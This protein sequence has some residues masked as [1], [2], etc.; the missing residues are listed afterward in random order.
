M[1]IRPIT[2]RK[3]ADDILIGGCS[4]TDLAKEYGT[5]LYVLDAATIQQNCQI[6]TKILTEHYPNFSIAYASKA[7]LNIG[8]ANLIAF[9]GIGADVVSGGE[10][11]TVLKSQ[12]DP[13][14]IYFHGNNKSIEELELAIANHIRLVV[15]NA[16]EVALIETIATRLNKKA[17][18]MFRIKP[19]I[20]AHT[21]EYIKTGHIDSKFG[22]EFNDILPLI[23]KIHGSE[24]G[25]FIGI[26]AHIGSQIFDMNPYYDL[27]SILVGFMDT[28]YSE[29]GIDIPELNCGGGFGIKYTE[30]DQA[31]DITDIIL[32]MA[33]ELKL[34]CDGKKRPRPKLVFEPGRS[35]IANAGV[36]IYT[37][38]TSKPISDGQQYLFIDG[39]M[40]D[41]PR[42][43]MYQSEY[44]FDVV[45]PSTTDQARYT[46]AGKFCESGDILAKNIVLPIVKPSEHIVVYGTGAYNYSMASNYNRF[47][48]PAM[49]LVNN[50]VASLL[51]KRETYEDIIRYDAL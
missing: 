44:T 9:E 15:D 33:T 24:W 17:K 46:I 27:V 43:M 26:H 1:N 19:G 12:I 6:F 13:K 50:N 36:T 3:S 39:G 40:A 49:I 21:H 51:I 25:E 23:K 29:F 34:L 16:Y 30:N 10:L 28:I 37:A 8:I 31:P 47:C 45:S 11:Y 32:G 42:P 22:F 20:E 2:F 18:M 38:G 14:K 4:L 7:G 35:I 48:K 41:N 5:P